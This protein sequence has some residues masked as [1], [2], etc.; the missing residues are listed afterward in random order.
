MNVLAL[1]M[2]ATQAACTATTFGPATNGL[3]DTGRGPS[4]RFGYDN[5]VNA[6]CRDKPAACASPPGEEP[7]LFNPLREVATAGGSVVAV[8]KTLDAATQQAIENALVQCANNARTDVLLRH[9]NKQHFKDLFP[10]ANECNQ[11]T[12]DARGRKVTWATRLGLEMH[13]EAQ[14]CAEQ[15]LHGLRPGGYSLEQR[16]RYDRRTRSKKPVSAAEE[17]LL[18]Q[19]G[20]IGE[21]AGTLKPDVVIHSG[22][23]LDVKAV[24]DFKF[25]C[26][27]TDQPPAWGRYSDGPYQGSD[28][29]KIYKEAF[30]PNVSRVA[31]RLGVVR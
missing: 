29:G 19:T 3:S 22:D 24:Y 21:L 23:P 14:K 5:T 8:L 18:E 6:T 31:P 10:T 12:Q 11:P 15:Y 28:Q 16:Y 7:A 20:N 30:G 2:L 4:G 26:V 27:S 9:K 17:S 25:P 13:A 1:V